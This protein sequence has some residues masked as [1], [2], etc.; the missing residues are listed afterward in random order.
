MKRLRQ[1]L[2]CRRLERI[3]AANRKK[4]NT[5]RKRYAKALLPEEMKSI[6]KMRKQGLSFET[7]A[8][9]LCRS[10]ESIRVNYLKE[11][12]FSASSRVW[13][14]EHDEMLRKM[15]DKKQSVEAMSDALHRTVAAIKRRLSHLGFGPRGSY[16]EYGHMKDA[17]G[18]NSTEAADRV[19]ATEGSAKLLEAYQLFYEKRAKEVDMPVEYVAAFYGAGVY[20]RA[21]LAA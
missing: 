10:K 15:V 20:H 16:K 11:Q 5:V 13:L 17:E 3:T 2:A 9:R 19:A 14:G 1:W 6:S 8:R 7:I 12:G 21:A 18:I 4:G